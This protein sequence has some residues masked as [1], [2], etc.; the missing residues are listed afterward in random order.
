MCLGPTKGIP[1][2]GVQTTREQSKAGI[3]RQVQNLHVKERCLIA[4]GKLLE[5][6]E[7]RTDM[8]KVCKED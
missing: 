6:L 4:T 1:I 8:K 2:A 5:V 7:S 3:R